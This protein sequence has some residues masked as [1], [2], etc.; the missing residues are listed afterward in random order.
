MAAGLVE[1]ID[2]EFSRTIKVARVFFFPRHMAAGLVESVDRE[3]SRTIKIARILCSSITNRNCREQNGW[4]FQIWES[5]F[6]I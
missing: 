5:E 1:S 4:G 2:S 6:A 3:L